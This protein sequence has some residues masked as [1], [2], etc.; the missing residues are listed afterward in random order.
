[1]AVL[2][3]ADESAKVAPVRR[4]RLYAFSALLVV[5]S[6]LLA[7]CTPSGLVDSSPTGVD[8]CLDGLAPTTT[9]TTGVFVEP[10]DS[11][12]PVLDELNAARCT[13]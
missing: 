8:S 6:V 4:L 11:R 13:I 9:D 12:D 5:L 1:M 7:S 10:D 3:E 2:R